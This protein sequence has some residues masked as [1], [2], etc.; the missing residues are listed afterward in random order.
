LIAAI[1]R[2]ALATALMQSAAAQDVRIEHVTIVSPER[3]GP[4]PDA[5]VRIHDGRIASISGSVAADSSSGGSKRQAID[6][7]GLYLAPGLIDSHVH[8]GSVPGMTDEQEAKHPDLARA[9]RDQMP[10]SFLLYGFTTLIDLISTP[11]A[12]KR[13]K[14]HAIVPDTFFCGGAALMDGYPMNYAPKPQR[15]QG[16]PYLLIEPGTPTPPGIDPAMH[17][18]DAVVARMKADGAICVKTFYERGFGGVRDLPVPRL[19]TIRALV[20]A[21]HTAGLPVLLH[22]NTSEAQTFGLSAGVDILAH[23]LWRWDEASSTTAVTPA[24]RK[25]LDGVLS[26]QVGWQ[27]TIQVLYGLQDLSRDS[28]L[29]DPQLARVLPVGLIEWYRSAEGQWFR[30]EVSQSLPAVKGEDPHAAVA[31]FQSA[32]ATA[33]D[34]VEHATGYLASHDARLLFGTDTPSAPTYANPPGLN[35][36]FEMQRLISAGVTPAQIFRAATLSNAQAFKLDRDIGTVQVG[37]RANLLLLHQD[38]TQ[39]IQAY[40]GIAKIIL[41]GRVLEPAELLA[42]RTRQ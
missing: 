41:A 15:Y 36:W 3:A 28:Y 20:R 24:I 33:I 13:W 7:R 9:A 23:G 16:M 19:D 4:M 6:G 1:A 40:A 26:G 18:P 42:N 38:P 22:A 11:E 34:R 10:R 5:E 25:I 17:T 29:A 37:K 30:D 31:R 14:S 21:A 12:I 2:L 8:L 35:A 32:F 27:P 39:S